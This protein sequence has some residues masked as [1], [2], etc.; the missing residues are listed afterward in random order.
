M[1]SAL[2]AIIENL[3]ILLLLLTVVPQLTAKGR[4]GSLVPKR[5]WSAG[6]GIGQPA[7]WS[8]LR[9]FPHALADVARLPVREVVSTLHFKTDLTLGLGTVA[10][11][12]LGK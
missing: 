1:S 6:A 11:D 8:A 4:Y 3:V 12:Y 5:T 9:L 2:A 7:S 10:F